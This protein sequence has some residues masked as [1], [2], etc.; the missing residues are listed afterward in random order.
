VTIRHYNQDTVTRMTRG[1][2]V[3]IEQRTR[4]TARFVLR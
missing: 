1:K 4:H 3:L 2:E